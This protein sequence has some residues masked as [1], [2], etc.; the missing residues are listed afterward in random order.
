MSILTSYPRR[1]VVRLTNW[2]GDALMNTPAL[3]ALRRLYPGAH[4]AVI[5]RPWVAPL[6]EHNPDVDEIILYDNPRGAARLREFARVAWQLRRGGFELGVAFQNAFEAAL[7]LRAGG[8]RQRVGYARDGRQW[9]LTFPVEVRPEDLAVHET[10]YYLRIVRVLGAP[11]DETGSYRLF[12]DPAEIAAMRER[13]AAEGY[14]EETP[15]VALNPGATYGSAKRWPPGRFAAVADELVRR[16]GVQVV[17][18]GS[19]DEA[20]VA[21]E[22]AGQMMREPAMI[23]S[24]KTSL[25]ELAALLGFC[26][27]L[28]SNDS[29]AMHVACARGVP[30][31]ALI[32]STDPRTTHPWGVSYRLVRVE[33]DCA[34]CLLRTCPTDHRCM[35]RLTTE[36]F[37]EQA[38]DFVEQMLS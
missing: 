28:V 21:R 34:P 14:R 12:L 20:P 3:H 33:A 2:I 26:R 8:V 30:V 5:A 15:L 9:L 27:L 17:I 13:L 36:V 22:I 6:F 32:G 35:E 7:L 18:V 31:V 10:S 23:F 1:I 29:G 4:L 19:P 25:R 24:G 16:H 38:G 37:W 11:V